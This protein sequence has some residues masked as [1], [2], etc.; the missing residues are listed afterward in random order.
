M[1]NLV[2]MWVGGMGGG[3]GGGVWGG[4]G[5]GGWGGGGGGKQHVHFGG[6]PQL[7]SRNVTNFWHSHRDY[8]MA[9]LIKFE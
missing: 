5:G 2:R 4:G 3:G 9:T 7:G 1:L 8:A 6:S